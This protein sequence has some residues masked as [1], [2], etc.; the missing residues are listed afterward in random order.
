M[1]PTSAI[2]I[3]CKVFNTDDSPET[4]SSYS[5]DKTCFY[6]SLSWNENFGER[7]FYSN[8]LILWNFGDSTISEGSSASHYY[9]YPGLYNVNATIFDKNGD[10]YDITLEQTLTSENVF[11]DLVYLYPLNTSGLAYNH[12]SGKPTNQIIVN[13]YNS[14]QNEKFIKDN[15][16]KINLYAY[17]SNSDYMGL[18]SYYSNKYSHLKSY[19]GFV[20]VSVTDDGFIQTKLTDSTK[21]DS[22][23]VYAI[24]YNTGLIDNDW[25]IKFDFYNHPIEGSSFVGTS[26]TNKDIDYV[27]F[28]DQKASDVEIGGADILYASFDSKSFS[29][30]SIEFNNLE[31]VFKKSEYGYLNTPWS[32]QILKSIFNS[33]SSLRI[34]S[35]GISVEGNNTTIGAISGQFVYPFDIY[36][37]KWANSHIPFV[38]TLKDPENYT[39]KNYK[40]IYNFHQGNFNNKLYDINLKLIQYISSDLT[41][42]ASN[43]L[44]AFELKEAI[45]TKN[46]NVPVYD[47]SSYFAG[48]V[49]LPFEAKTVAISAT[50]KIQDENVYKNIPIYGFL[51][52]TGQNKI[53]RYSK[54]LVF[55]YCDVEELL[56]YFDRKI[57]TFTDPLTSNLHICFSPIGMF[58]DTKQNRIYF[59]DGDRDKI[60][61][62]DIEGTLI[63]TIAFS[64][65]QYRSNDALAPSVISMLNDK[66]SA[67][68]AW[69]SIDKH[70]NA[71]VTLNDS[72]SSFKFDYDTNIAVRKYVPPFDNLKFYQS[73]LA[74]NPTLSGIDGGNSIT[75]S[76]IDVDKDDNVYI[77][78][79]NPLSSFICKYDNDG[80]VISVINFEKWEIPQEIIIDRSGNIWVGIEN[81]NFSKSDNLERNDLVYFIDSQTLEK[82]IV[83]NIKGLGNM[84]IDNQQNLYVTTKT[85][86]ITKIDRLTKLKTDYTFGESTNENSYIKDIGAIAIDSENQIWAVNNI[87]GKIYFVDLDNLNS[88]LSSWSFEKLKEIN[89][90]TIQ[91][92]QS[93]YYTTGDWTGFRWINKFSKVEI[94]EPRIIS[95]QSSYFDIL[96][97]NP[98]VAKKG[99]EFDYLTQLK[100]YILQ[101]SLFDRKILLDDFIG[102]ILGK[103]ENVQEIGKVIY[104]KISNFVSNNSDI[105]TCNI[106]QLISLADETGIDLN[107]YLYSYPPS[108]RRALDILSITQRKL[109][110]SRNTYNRNFALS[111][112]R[113]FKN[114]NLGPEIDIETGIFFAGK[115]VVTY[116]LFSE[117]YKL[118]TNTIVPNYNYGDIVPL[119]GVNYDWGWELV[120]GTREQSGSEI[121][122]YYKFYEFVPNST[123]EFYDNLLN[124]NSKFTT[125][126]P[127]QSSFEDWSKFAG[128]M[129]KILSYG[130]YDGLK[131]F[132]FI[133]PTPSMTPSLTPT[134]TPTPTPTVSPTHT[135]TNTM[136]P[137]ETPTNT[138]TPK[139]TPTPTI[140][141]TQTSTT[142]PTNTP[143]PTPTP[144]ETLTPTPTETSTPTPTP[145]VTQTATPTPTITN[146]PTNTR[147]PTQTPPLLCDQNAQYNG[148]QAFP[149]INEVI[150]GL[151]TGFVNLRFDAFTVP[152]RFVVEFDGLTAIDTGYRGDPSY[153]PLLSSI[154]GEFTPI[155]SPG[156]GT[157]SFFKGTSNPKAIVK[158]FAPLASTGWNFNLSCPD[159]NIPS[160]TPT[161][162]LTRTPTR[163]ITPTR[164]LTRTP[165]LTQSSSPTPVTPTPTP[166]E[167]PTRTPTP[168][169]TPIPSNTPTISLTPSITQSISF[170]PS[171]TQS[172]SLTPT[173]S[174]TSVTPTPTFTPYVTPSLSM[175]FTPTET[176]PITP[177]NTQTPTPTNTPLPLINIQFSTNSI[178]IEVRGFDFYYDL[179]QIGTN[180]PPMTCYRGMNYDFIIKDTINYPFALRVSN[181]DAITQVSGAFNNDIINGKTSGV[182]MFTPDSS[183]PSEIIYQSVNTPSMFGTITILDQ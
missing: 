121:K 45:F 177:T 130:F 40:Q 6:F 137:T 100:S 70:G 182:I 98:I 14:W 122:K 17:G 175:T 62:S 50:L 167:T 174:P 99:E 88:P 67:S 28:V 46:D 161:I 179:S 71:Y 8:E 29:D 125:I 74:I 169:F 9:K 160:P 111:A 87:D 65:V 102:Q 124:F 151:D 83:R 164:T 85:N 118:I 49:Y 51:A 12:P 93:L 112:Y 33:A 178:P 134:N 171:I 153:E 172:I 159:P 24:P 63:N 2:K 95:G 163:T 77:A 162:S 52:Q 170:T 114:N 79:T 41:L 158:V 11:P 96:N 105:E 104:E 66:K 150:L 147:T 18:S 25:S 1:L 141:V 64:A 123:N 108:I 140:T 148:G 116:E 128:S 53:R 143:T 19:H 152:D 149:S 75:P 10:P 36:P 109:F 3:T 181:G 39:T 72:V 42:S 69:C 120:T 59:L 54:Q 92:L 156:N 20:N 101:E 176:L 7:N 115:P 165:T 15:G 168:T 157:V 136:T 58:D 132:K 35:N 127:E 30:K 13:R 126:T 76:C 183:T 119:S 44:S 23:S 142:T 73:N 43:N 31:N 180:S 16:Y 86:T 97:P 155:T 80:N 89:L 5:L 4:F 91:G 82:T 131:M 117:K 27:Y 34:T 21:T 55:D 173:S 48:K 37:V 38:I 57:I 144:T 146:S 26:G 94:P 22:V 56:F 133:T 81:L 103:D 61:I 110:G 47:N 60:H 138:P 129:D 166:T 106:Q 135:P 145:T 68:P 90:N 84:T 107:E 113:Y 32:A 139:F 78:Y 154:L